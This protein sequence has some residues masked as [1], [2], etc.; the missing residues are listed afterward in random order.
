MLTLILDY[1]RF[2]HVQGHSNKE[3][4]SYDDKFVWIDATRLCELMSV[5]KYLQLEPLYDLTCHAIARIIE[6]RSSEEIHD[7]FHLPDDLMEEE[8]L[9]QM[10]NITCD[11]SIR[12]MNCLYAKKRKQLKK[13]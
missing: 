3:Q 12:L 9:E 5:A 1:C 2:D 4:K 10:L 13:M 6:G 8:K 7:I 11:P